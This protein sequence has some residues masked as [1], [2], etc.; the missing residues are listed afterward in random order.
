MKEIKYIELR[1]AFRIGLLFYGAAVGIISL[2]FLAAE[3]LALAGGVFSLP[4]FLIGSM[5]LVLGTCLYVVL[6]GVAVASSV[7]LYNQI[8]RKYGGIKIKV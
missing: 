8:A 2:I 3:V 5:V 1:S 6:G 7:W 4:E